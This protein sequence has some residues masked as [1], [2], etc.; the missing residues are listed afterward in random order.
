MGR[1]AILLV[2]SAIVP[3][4][5]QAAETLPCVDA[6]RIGAYN[7]RPISSHAVLARNASGKDKRTLRLGTTCT[8]IDR[9]ATISLRSLNQCI[10]KGDEV[11]AVTIDGHHEICRI[12]SVSPGEEFTHANYR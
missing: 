11:A 9:T 5:A 1:M 3:A 4:A 8:H 6:S 7:A 10:G 2:M 12:A